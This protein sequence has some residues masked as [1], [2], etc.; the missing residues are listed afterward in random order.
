MDCAKCLDEMGIGA[1]G[2]QAME[3]GIFLRVI[4]S[5]KPH[6]KATVENF[7][8]KEGILFDDYYKTLFFCQS[9][10]LTNFQ[11]TYTCDFTMVR[12][13][14]WEGPKA[15][16][17]LPSIPP[18]C[19]WKWVDVVAV[20]YKDRPVS[21]IY[22]IQDKNDGIDVWHYVLVDKEMLDTFLARTESNLSQYG[23]IIKSG[24]GR[25]PPSNVSDGFLK[26]SPGYAY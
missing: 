26:W 17:K 5:C 14:Q 1:C 10:N 15:P 9:K 25:N 13:L 20:D 11:T 7:V 22:L 4:A 6:Q 8:V 21:R 16:C 12:C 19:S 18:R 2:H 24:W 23:H 3:Q